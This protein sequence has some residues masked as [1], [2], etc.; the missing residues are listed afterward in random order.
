VTSVAPYDV[1]LSENQI[2]IL[3]NLAEKGVK[4]ITAVVERV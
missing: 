2:N 3:V 1:S 4:L